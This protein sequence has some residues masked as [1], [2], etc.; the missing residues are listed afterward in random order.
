M[1]MLQAVVMLL[2][3][4]NTSY[5]QIPP[6]FKTQDTIG[7]AKDLAFHFARCSGFYNFLSGLFETLDEPSLAEYLHD[8]SEKY[9]SYALMLALYAE[10]EPREAFVNHY[11]DGM[12]ADL[13]Q[14]A[15]ALRMLDAHCTAPPDIQERIFNELRKKG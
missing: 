3:L 4:T 10:V 11:I 9:K 6:L 8:A 7:E 14:P 15:D 5:A 1:R 13:P 12:Q 2:L